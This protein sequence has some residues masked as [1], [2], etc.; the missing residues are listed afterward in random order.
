MNETEQIEQYLF[1]R[2]DPEEMILMDARCL[3]DAQLHDN[4][5]WQQRTYALIHYY[6]RQK[7]RKEIH[8]VQQRLFSE[9]RFDQFR[10]KIKNIFKTP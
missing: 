2:L 3:V 7:L 5:Q 4:I 10:N 9:S 8:Q 1:Q 6:G